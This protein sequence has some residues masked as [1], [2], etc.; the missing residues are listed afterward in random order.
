MTRGIQQK[1]KEL[2][3]GAARVLNQL[4]GLEAN[5]AHG[6]D[7]DK[8]Y[9]VLLKPYLEPETNEQGKVTT[10]P[11]VGFVQDGYIFMGG[12]PSKPESWRPANG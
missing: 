9:E 1:T 4:I 12:D 3:N 7:L 5:L 10:T 11:K 2:N 6:G 8:A